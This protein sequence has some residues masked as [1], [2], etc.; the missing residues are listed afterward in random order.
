MSDFNALMAA[1]DDVLIST[2]NVDDSVTLWPGTSRSQIIEGVFDNPALLTGIP[3]GGKFQGSDPS[4][5]AHDR[6]ITQLKK[7]DAVMIS[8]IQW[9]VKSLQPDGSGITR[10]FLSKYQKSDQDRPGNLL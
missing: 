5:T 8:N 2:F 9:Y 3:D 10:V 6:D 7:K 4:F 1:A